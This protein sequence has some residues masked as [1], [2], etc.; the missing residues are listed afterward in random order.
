MNVK[1]AKILYIEDDRAS[2]LL[3]KQVLEREGYR[4]LEAESGLSGLELA[5][6]ERPDLILMDI[7]LPDISGTELTTKIKTTPELEN[8]KVVALS[9]LKG[10]ENRQIFLVAGCDGFI[11]KPIDQEQFPSQIQ[12][13]LAGLR[14]EIPSASQET[15]R[16]RYQ[17]TLVDRLTS[18]VEELQR[19]N[20]LLQELTATLQ[21]YNAK[22]EQLHHIVLQLQ[23]CHSPE[24]LKTK[25][26]ASICQ[27][28]NI[29]RCAFLEIDPKHQQLTP[30]HVCGI[31]PAVLKQLQIPYREQRFKKMF[32]ES[33]VVVIEKP[34]QMNEASIRKHLEHTDS[35]PF[36]FGMLG[37]PNL[38]PEN[39][40]DPHTVQEML[41]VLG[42]QLG[43]EIPITQ[44]VLRDHVQEFLTPE[45]FRPGGF[46]YID[47]KSVPE[48]A[49]QHT[50][51]L[52]EMLLRTASL[53]YHNLLLRIQLRQLFIHAETEAITDPLT[54][55]YNF[56]YLMLQLER[57]V[58]R[59]Q[60]HNAPLSLL[61]I[62]IDFF[63]AFN[64]TFGHLAGNKILKQLARLL[65]ENTRS[66]DIV[67]RYGGE[68]FMVICPELDRSG[69]LKLAEKIRRMVAQTRFD[70][71]NR[72]FHQNV[73]VSIGVAAFPQDGKS[74][75]SLIRAADVAMYSAKKAGR[76]KV[77]AFSS[78]P[79]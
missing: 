22:L 45:M 1:R 10:E 49:R 66:T 61:M 68:E 21:D 48:K 23:L 44:D 72:P 30:R 18:K 2:R 5:Q 33:Q 14:E 55:L 37:I 57:E 13:F 32:M 19:S 9:A 59:S 17:K 71:E 35:F 29:S 65:Q 77:A 75:R 47:L 8:I 34:E 60:R 6:R 27:S 46:L 40:L 67:G 62:D 42:K 11:Q 36:I 76:N 3:V 26:Y 64:D 16:R 50:V 79:S 52:L 15:I 70:F 20:R 12:Q 43:E 39:L 78:A 63:K 56:R 69:A 51:Q 28:F 74:V 58:R 73:T 53:I 24:Q 7:N 38:T 25:L 31:D 4:V 41:G 54:G